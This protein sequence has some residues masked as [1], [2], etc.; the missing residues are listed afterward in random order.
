MTGDVH[1]HIINRDRMCIGILLRQLFPEMGVPWHQCRNTYGDP[2]EPTDLL[3]LTVDHFHHHAGGTKG[4]RAESD[5]EHGTAACGDL[6]GNHMSALIRQG[7]R[8]Y[9]EWLREQNRL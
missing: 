8:R 3:Q 1:R 6:N 5:P 9:I 7:Q 2:H 4:K